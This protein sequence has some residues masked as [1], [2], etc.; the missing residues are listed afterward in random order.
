MPTDYRSKWL[1][2]FDRLD[3]AISGEMKFSITLVDPLANSYVQ[4]LF[5]PEPDPQLTI[6]EYDRTD[7]EEDD[8]GLKD[9]KTEGY[10]EEHQAFLERERA[11]ELENAAE[12]TTNDQTPKPT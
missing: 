12:D 8:L 11:R 4:D 9:M 2:F 5:S 3:K 7:E 6:E 1:R 10:E